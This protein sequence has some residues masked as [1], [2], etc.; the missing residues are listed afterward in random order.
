[1]RVCVCVRACVCMCVCECVCVRSVSII[2]TM[3]QHLTG[4]MLTA[5]KTQT[6]A[7]LMVVYNHIA[8]KYSV[9]DFPLICILVWYSSGS[10]RRGKLVDFAVYAAIQ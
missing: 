9:L 3:H 6:V 8:R 1:M 5:V 10:M 7:I 2:L 4:K